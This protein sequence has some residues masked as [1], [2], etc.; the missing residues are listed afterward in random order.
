MQ[1][2]FRAL[3]IGAEN[4]TIDR[5]DGLEHEGKLWLVPQWLDV[6]ALGVTKPARLI[7]FDSLAHQHT[8][9]LKYGV[10]YVVNYPIP[11]ELFDVRTP[12][13]PIA[14]FE[15]VELPAI[16]FPLPNKNLN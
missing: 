6:P 7:R 1:R 13:K 10:E 5:C 9:D 14:G 3:I 12:L 11:K 15:C 8:P 16:A 2:R 4:G